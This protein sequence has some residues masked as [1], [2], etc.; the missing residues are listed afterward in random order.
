VDVLP[1]FNGQA[2]EGV[3]S[4]QPR[5]DAGTGSEK[6]AGQQTLNSH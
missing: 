6:A 3:R 1:G 2:R 5:A 4:V